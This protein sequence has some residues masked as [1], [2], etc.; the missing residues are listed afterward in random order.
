[1]R[2]TNRYFFSL[3]ILA[4][5]LTA[6]PDLYAQHRKGNSH[7]DGFDFQMRSGVNFSQI[8]G[9]ASGN[10]NKIGIHA[11]FNTSYPLGDN[12]FRFLVEIGLTQKGSKINNSSIDRDISLLYVEIPLMI[13]YNTL[14]DQLRFGVGVAPAILA[15][16]YVKSDGAYDALH[17]ENYKPLDA[18]PVCLSVGYRFTEHVGVDLRWYNSMLNIAKENGS[19]TYRLFRSNKGQF[20][21]L[22]QFGLTFSF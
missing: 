10:Y 1:M 22:L 17:S 6:A 8:D 20:N 13:T 16:S 11:A 2:H 18:L 3:L 15:R 5:I 14:E 12:G 19:G 7:R 4:T 21:R 9:D